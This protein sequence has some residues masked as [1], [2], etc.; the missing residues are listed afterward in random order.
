[1][2]PALPV[3][4]PIQLLSGNERSNGYCILSPSDYVIWT[5]IAGAGLDADSPRRTL[6]DGRSGS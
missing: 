3:T 5:L 1:M 2:S 4:C 6:N